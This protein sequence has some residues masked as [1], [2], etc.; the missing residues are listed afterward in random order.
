MAIYS[1]RWKSERTVQR[2]VGDLLEFLHSGEAARDI[3]LESFEPWFRST[4]RARGHHVASSESTARGGIDAMVD[5]V[6]HSLKCYHQTRNTVTIPL[7]EISADEWR[8]AELKGRLVLVLMNSFWG[9]NPRY[10]ELTLE[11]LKQLE[12][13]TMKPDDPGILAAAETEKE[14]TAMASQPHSNTGGRHPGAEAGD[15]DNVL[16]VE[17]TREAAHGAAR[18]TREAAGPT[19]EAAGPAGD[20]AGGGVETREPDV[21]SPDPV[22][23]FKA[24][25]EVKP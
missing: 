13:I 2:R 12:N 10:K 11:E 7:T 21:T 18:P 1:G 19:L 22:A 8:A 16:H 20:A 15:G 23:Y 5:G 17:Q 3:G 9:T 4:M 25:E 6:V 24:V 14:P